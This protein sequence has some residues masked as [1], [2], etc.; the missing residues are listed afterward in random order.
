MKKTALVCVGVIMFSFILAAYF[1]QT[2]PER[3]ATH[4]N[5]TGEV[6]GYTEKFLGVFLLPTLSLILYFIFALFQKI[7]PL[8][9]NI[10]LFQRYYD[11]FIIIV[12]LFLFYV[13]S[14]IL[15]WNMGYVFSMNLALPPAFAV[16]FYYVGVLVEN[17]K[18]NWFIGIRTPWTLSSQSVWDKTHRL[19]G[20]LI[21]FCGIFAL[22]GVFYPRYA[23][24]VIIA[25]ILLVSIYLF[26]YSYL[27]YKKERK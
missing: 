2:L 16:L 24:Y 27:E 23:I 3:M 9:E 17:A 13:Q 6:D 12:L 10:K 25:P 1:Y 21:K 15:V 19:G 4:W 14:L 18:M 5:I 22:L 7:D 8:K 26:V 20:R 11:G